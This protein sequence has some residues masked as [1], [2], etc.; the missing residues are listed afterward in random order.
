MMTRRSHW[1]FSV[2]SMFTPISRSVLA[3]VIACG[4]IVSTARV[5][6]DEASAHRSW[7]GT[8]YEGDSREPV[9]SISQFSD[10]RPTD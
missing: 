5:G 8:G 3:A 10:V 6:A 2:K 7:A 4:S 9:A 1:R